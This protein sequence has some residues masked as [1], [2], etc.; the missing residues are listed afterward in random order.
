MPAGA[1]SCGWRVNTVAV[2]VA[3]GLCFFVYP[4]EN[5]LL[6]G[7]ALIALANVFFEFANVNYFAMLKQVSTPGTIGK[8]SGF[9]WA[10]GYVGG[11][12]ALALVLVGF[13]NPDVGW[14]GVTSENGQNIRA[15]A[16]FSAAWFLVFSLPIFFTVPEVPRTTRRQDR[17]LRLLRAAVPP[18]QG[19]LQDQPAHHLLPAGQCGVPGRA[20]GSLHLRRHHCGRNLRLG[21]ARR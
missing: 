5:F 20:G 6:L 18:D 2:C 16:L 8:V 10:M 14:F 12:A 21:A 17:L 11:I 19:H 7:V 1:A 13:I 4:S 3:T 15:V 9:G